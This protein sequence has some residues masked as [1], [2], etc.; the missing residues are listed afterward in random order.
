MVN[1]R[2]RFSTARPRVASSSA[3]STMSGEPFRDS[4]TIAVSGSNSSITSLLRRWQYPARHTPRGSATTPPSRVAQRDL[5]ESHSIVPVGTGAVEMPIYD[6]AG[7][8]ATMASLP[9]VW[10]RTIAR[11]EHYKARG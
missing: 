9:Y 10:C 3:N 4:S 8:K 7:L 2:R 5:L 6:C 1:S 11:T